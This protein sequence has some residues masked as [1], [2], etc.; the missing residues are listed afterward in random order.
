MRAATHPQEARM[1]VSRKESDGK[2]R[3]RFLPINTAIINIRPS[4]VGVGGRALIGALPV[5]PL[6]DEVELSG[7]SVVVAP[8]SALV[9]RLLLLL[10]AWAG[11]GGGGG[12]GGA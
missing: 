2:L 9:V 1:W 6:D 11:L 3:W 10:M 5:L 4:V 7:V 8:K 12:V